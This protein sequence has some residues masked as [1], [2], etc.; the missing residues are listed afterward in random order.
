MVVMA[1]VLLL[2]GNKAALSAALHS[3]QKP[4]SSPS[5]VNEWFGMIVILV[6]LDPATQFSAASCS[7][8]V[9]L[10]LPAKAI[11]IVPFTVSSWDCTLGFVSVAGVGGAE[12]LAATGISKTVFYDKKICIQE[13]CRAF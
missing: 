2:S 8:R 12:V 9:M 4:C 3:Q 1:N 5:G 11:C 10:R 6:C 7:C 13:L